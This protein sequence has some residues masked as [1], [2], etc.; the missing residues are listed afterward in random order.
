MN[1]DSLQGRQTG[2]LVVYR[3]TCRESEIV[4]VAFAA[5]PIDPSPLWQTGIHL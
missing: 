4:F 2:P 5:H 1:G 3:Q